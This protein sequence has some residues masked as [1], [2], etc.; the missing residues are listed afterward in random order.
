MR[1]LLGY[2]KLSRKRNIDIRRKLKVGGIVEE[3]KSYQN[4]WKEHLLKM[5]TNRLPHLAFSYHPKGKRSI[6]HPTEMAQDHHRPPEWK[7]MIVYLFIC[8]DPRYGALKEDA[9]VLAVLPF[10]HAYMFISQLI[11]ICAGI[12]VI[13]MTQFEEEMFLKAIQNHKVSK[14]LFYYSWTSIS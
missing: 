6:R 2:T 4:E 7:M 14:F 11:C 3:I 1:P 8:R 10:F 12:K 13:V 5:N 9:V